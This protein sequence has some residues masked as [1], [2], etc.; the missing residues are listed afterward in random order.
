MASGIRWFAAA[1]AL[2]LALTAH[3]H[4]PRPDP[5]Q[6]RSLPVPRAEHARLVSLGF[7]ALAA[8]FY[9]LRAVQVIG[10]ERS[11][12]WRQAATVGR[13][14]ETVVA[15]DPWVDHPYRFAALWMSESQP[16]PSASP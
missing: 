16:S 4:L 8:D 10:A 6:E 12:P 13:L 3:A 9:W 7:D 2:A 5:T 11:N 14:A 15:L 1:G